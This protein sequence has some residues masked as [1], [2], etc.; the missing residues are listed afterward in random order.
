MRWPIVA[1][2]IAAAVLATVALPSIEESQIGALGA[3]VPSH[4][5][6]LD[7]ELRSSELFGFPLLSRTVVVQ[8]DP[9][10]LSA[11]RAGVDGRARGRAR[12]QRRSRASSG[13]AARSPVLNTVSMPPFTREHGTTA[14][15]FLYFG[16]DVGS[17][18]RLELAE[19]LRRAAQSS[20]PAQLHRGDGRDRGA[21][22]A[23]AADLRAPAARR[24]AARC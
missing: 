7:A 22:G 2:W 12:S 16:P 20:E 10:G 17:G 3:L 1:G 19:R 23:V 5:D 18:E 13:S 9:R 4:S 8:R 11:G 24:A 21:R 6:A 15:T 14:V